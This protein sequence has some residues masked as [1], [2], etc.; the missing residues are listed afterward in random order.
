MVYHVIDSVDR[1]KPTDW[2]RV[3]AIFV[4]GQKWQFRGW[5]WEE[6]VDIF[7]RST[8]FN[9]YLFHIDWFSERFLYQIYRFVG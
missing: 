1:M 9:V 4:T 2:D 8:L 7:S 5:R 3:V 6:P